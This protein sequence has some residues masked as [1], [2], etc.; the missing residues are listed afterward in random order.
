MK[1]W[2]I[3]LLLLAASAAPTHAGS[4]EDDLLQAVRAGDVAAVKAL[5]DQGVPVDT[6]FRYDRTPLSFAADRGNVEMV[7]LL[8]DRGASVDAEDTFYHS[9]PLGSAAYKGHAEVVRL[10]LARTTKGVGDALL[11]GVFAK[12][13]EV[14]EAVL[15]TG[16]VSARDLSY[17]LEAALKNGAT[18]VAEQL[19]K[20]GAVPPPKAEATVDAAVLARYA[21]RYRQENGAE[22]FTLGVADGALQATFGGRTFKLGAIDA[23]HFQHPEATGVTLEMRLEGDRVVGA[24]M[25]EIGSELRYQRV[26]EAKP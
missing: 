1:T 24:T 9:T 12:K 13:P 10:L 21:G 8:L 19:R 23:L 18:E 11:S 2:T 16:K 15:A 26:E 14:V 7:K 3:A 4:R 20:A 6:K 5:L 17:T 22:E 25:A